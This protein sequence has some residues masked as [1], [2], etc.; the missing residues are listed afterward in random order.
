LERALALFFEHRVFVNRFDQKGL[1]EP[2]AFAVALLICWHWEFDAISTIIVHERMTLLGE[3]VT[4]GV[5]AGGSKASIKLFH[6][7]MNVRSRA[8]EARHPQKAADAGP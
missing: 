7:L 2:I 8:H 3:A 5:V 1:K 4:A 6:D